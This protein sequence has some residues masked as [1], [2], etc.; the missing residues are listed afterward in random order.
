M[1]HHNRSPRTKI[2]LHRLITN[3]PQTLDVDHR[4]HEGL[5]CRRHNLF[6]SPARNNQQNKEPHNSSGFKGVYRRGISNRWRARITWEGKLI[7]IGQYPTPEE[8]AKAY[9]QKALELYGPF[10]WVNFPCIRQVV[11]ARNPEEIPF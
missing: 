8:A 4:N 11:V 2:Y 10:A 5:D 6:V 1:L 7:N 3:A 9:D